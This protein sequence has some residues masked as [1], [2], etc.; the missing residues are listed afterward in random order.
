M[1]EAMLGKA[2]VRPEQ[3]AASWVAIDPAGGVYSSSF[4]NY[5]ISRR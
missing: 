2:Y 1:I 5:E 4:H 3:S